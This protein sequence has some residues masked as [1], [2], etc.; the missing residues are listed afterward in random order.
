MN[1]GEPEIESVNLVVDRGDSREAYSVVLAA[2][3]VASMNSTYRAVARFGM[4]PDVREFAV[5]VR[6]ELQELL[7]HRPVTVGREH[8]LALHDVFDRELEVARH[9]LP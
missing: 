4:V 6:A 8:V 5:L 3:P 7:G 2:C 9:R 1:V